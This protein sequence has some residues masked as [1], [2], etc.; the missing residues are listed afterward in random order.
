MTEQR[1]WV[2]TPVGLVCLFALGLAIRLFCARH[3]NGLWFD[4]TLFRQWSDR[5]VALGPARFYA[6]DYVVDYPPGYLYVLLALGKA[7]RMLLGEAPSVAVLKLPAIGADLGVA[8]LAVVMAPRL[9]PK[10]AGSQAPVRAAA[11]AAILFNPALILVSSVW[12]QVDSVFALLAFGAILALA[13]GRPSTVREAGGVMLLAV[14]LA[15]KPQT[16]LAIPLIVI[17]MARRHLEDGDF[18]AGSWIATAGR[19]ALLTLL[20]GAVVVLMFRPFGLGPRAILAFY[21]EAGSMYPT[22]SLW[23]FNV[24]GAFGFYRPDIGP[25]AVSL[26]GYPAFLLGAAAFSLATITFAWRGWRSLEDGVVT[27]G[28]AVAL[29]GAVAVTCA[30]FTLLTRMHERYLYLAVAGLAPFASDRRFRGALIVLSALFFFNVHFV[31]VYFAQHATPPEAVWTIQ[32]LYDALFGSAQN[33]WQLRLLS[34]LTAMTCLV[35][36]VVGWGWLQADPKASAAQ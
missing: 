3:S 30:G 7:S 19:A 33:A 4:V 35:L 1:K 25:T 2:E 16:I 21:H 36:A 22:T 15:T 6:P 20:A 13:T 12:G 18:T 14:A 28:T 31:Y 32:L 23:A 29:F 9:L 24:W 8:L 17:V 26:W 27:W 5:L 11:A 10:Q 34:A